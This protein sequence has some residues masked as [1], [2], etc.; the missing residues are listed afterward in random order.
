VS[1]PVEDLRAAATLLRETASKATAT[2]R[3]IP[4]C[5]GYEASAGGQIWSV[6]SNWRGYG[7]RPLQPKPNTDGY[8]KV[9]VQL[10][11]DRKN[12]PV[13]KL[14]AEAFLGARP[15]GM[16]VCHRDGNKLNNWWPNLRYGTAAENANDRAH[17]G[18]TAM[19]VSNGNGRLLDRDVQEIRELGQ[20][21][22]THPDIARKVGCSRAYVGMILSGQAR[23][24]EAR[25]APLSQEEL[26]WRWIALMSPAVAEPLAAWLEDAAKHAAKV[27]DPRNQEIIADLHALTVARTI[28]GRQP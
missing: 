5:P 3:P 20:Q 7:A 17:H 6:G 2:R 14:V 8:L 15:E 28:L 21:G 26:D 24:D 1:G 4:S 13:H 27:N 25:S 19:S 9:R 22:F 12:Y 18:R 10:G 16:Q 23:R 11:A